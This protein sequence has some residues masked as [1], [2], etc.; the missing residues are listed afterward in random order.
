MTAAIVALAAALAGTITGATDERRRIAIA[1]DGERAGVVT[2]VTTM[3]VRYECARFGDVGPLRVKATP[4]TAARVDRRG[5]F[6]FVTGNRAER[7]GVAGRVRASGTVT[8]RI[9]VSGTI[10]TGARCASKLVRFR[11]GTARQ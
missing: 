4:A 10:A 2:R 8:G 9:R 3:V 1:F 11:A 5:R 7:V 6:A